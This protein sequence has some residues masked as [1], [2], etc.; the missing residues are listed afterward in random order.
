VRYK[1]LDHEDRIRIEAWWAAGV[2]MA[3]IAVF[4]GRPRCTITREI[5][6]HGRYPYG[7]IGAVNPLAATLPPRRRPLYRLKYNAAYAQG[8]AD[9]DAPLRRLRP[10]EGTRK[11]DPGPLRELVVAKLKKRWSPAQI[12]RWLSHEYGTCTDAARWTVSHETIYQ[13]LYLQTRGALREELKVQVALRSGR[14]RRRTRPTAAGPVRSQRAWAQGWHLSQR[15]AE[16]DDRAVPGHWEGDLVIGAGGKSAMITCVERS[17]RYVLLG[18][19]PHGRD[20]HAVITV[21]TGLINTLP[22]HLRRSLTWD[23]GV[24]MARVADFRI[25]TD[26]PVYFCD[27]HSPW[28]RGSNENTN[29]L[30]RQYFPKGTHDFRTTTQDQLDDVAAELNG[31]PRQTLNWDNPAERLNALLLH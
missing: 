1:R 5:R 9:K 26:C 3:Q 25:A 12:S 29:G 17:T 23:G 31:R 16:A 10:V 20:S 21:L 28:Q 22:Q 14:Q 2:S 27:P 19:L 18:A 11:L 24:E 30:L 7:T 13:A 8:K 4:L 15:P 6:R